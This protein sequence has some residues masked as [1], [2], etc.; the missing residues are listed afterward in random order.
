MTDP[1]IDEIREWADG[2]YPS[3]EPHIPPKA[4]SY[5]RTLLAELDIVRA[6][7]VALARRLA[8]IEDACWPYDPKGN[9]SGPPEPP[10]FR[11]WAGVEP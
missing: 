11:E 9:S 6:D 5:T 7:R 8:F 3:G 2:H 1:T 4:P 10:G